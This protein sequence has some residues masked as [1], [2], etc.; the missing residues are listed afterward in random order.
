MASAALGVHMFGT[1]PVRPLA[2][3]GTV[4]VAVNIPDNR[5][6]I[7]KVLHGGLDP[8]RSVQFGLEPYPVAIANDGSQA[9]VLSHLSDSVGVVDLTL[10]RVVRTLLVGDEPSDSVMVDPDGAGPLL[11]RAFI[12]TVHR[13]QH[14]TDS[15]TSGEPGGGDPRLTTQ[16]VPH[17]DVWV[18]DGDNLGSGVGG[19]P[20]KIVELFADTPRALA[21]SSD[22][23][24]VYAA[25]FHSGDQ[26]AVVDERRVCNG[27]G[28]NDCSGD[29]RPVLY[30][31]NR[32]SSKAEASCSSCH[33]FGDFD[34]LA[35]DLGNPDDVVT[36]NPIFVNLGAFVSFFPDGLG[37]TINGTGNVQDFHPRK[38]PMTTQTLR[39]LAT[40]G[41]MHRRGDRSIGFFG[42]N[43]NDE[44]LSFR[45][46]IGA[47]NGLVGDTMP[48]TDPTRQ[49]DMQ[50]FADFM[51]QVLLP[52][53]PARRRF[54][55]LSRGDRT[56]LRRVPVTRFVSG[57]LWNGNLGQLR[58]RATDRQ[59]SSFPQ[60]VSK[61]W[62]VRHAQRGLQSPW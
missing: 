46:F 20:L 19:V 12:T 26:T 3:R 8:P 31:S 15:S 17:A 27:F 58:E 54:V 28:T 55:G 16:G 13:G 18:F 50:R 45:N 48:P 57:L 10:A 49:A 5:L 44:D 47:F 39:G 61:G 6:Q 56:Y 23:S 37:A 9:W 21:V 14:R 11:E 40:S 38:G 60:L 35:W 62:H 1:G 34:S 52:P 43:A 25:V 36:T 59:D 53:N 51:L 7:F 33:I 32:T 42:T 24:R 4:L 22:G 29:G 41:A 2:K 30:Y